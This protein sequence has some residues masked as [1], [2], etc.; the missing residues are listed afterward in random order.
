MPISSVSS[1]AQIDLA[2]PRPA[3]HHARMAAAGTSQRRDALCAVPRGNTQ[4]GVN[5][6][7][8]RLLEERL[9]R[10]RPLR[11][12]DAACGRGELLGC[13][14]DRFPAAELAGVDL[15]P[16]AH[17]DGVDLRAADLT[18]EFPFAA[19]ECFD[20]ITCVSGVMM[21]GNTQH[22]VDHCCRHLRPGGLLLLT[23]DNS[24]T[25]RDRLSYL[26]TGRFRRFRLFYEPD[27]GLTQYVP[28]QELH[29]LLGRHAVEIEQVVY[30]SFYAEDLLFLPAALLLYPLQLAYL[31]ATRSS[32]APAL[33]R[34]LFGFRALLHRHYV[35]V[36]R[37]T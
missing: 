8:I 9:E 12:L 32:V 4:R 27:E 30:T 20:I 28:L 22:F 31:L 29:R 13:L 25:V 37:R 7:I 18:R 26:F 35:L 6:T 36:A 24:F 19:D 3:L 34:R 33:R 5:A 17:L 10:D 16:P 2:E 14:R 23:N 11:L 1:R 21:F 15:E